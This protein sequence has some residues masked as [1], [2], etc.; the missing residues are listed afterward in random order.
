MIGSMTSQN[1]S[2]DW[3]SRGSL[4]RSSTWTPLHQLV[5]D[6]SAQNNVDVAAPT[7]VFQ[8]S[9]TFA[10]GSVEARV[11]E[12]LPA[13]LVIT[14]YAHRSSS[15]I[16][17]RE[18]TVSFVGCLK[19]VKFT[20]DENAKPVA[21]STNSLM[22]LYDIP[23]GETRL[24]SES[25]SS[26][27]SSPESIQPLVGASDLTFS[28]GTIKVF[29]F[30]LLPRDAG[31]V[32][33]TLAS[34]DIHEEFFDFTVVTPLHKQVSPNDWWLTCGTI[35]SKRKLTTD[36][37]WSI[38][39][40]PKPPKVDIHILNLLKSYYTD[41][42]VELQFTITNNEVE[43]A[44]IRFNVQ[45]QGS[46][47]KAPVVRWKSSSTDKGISIM[48]DDVRDE[49]VNSLNSQ[50]AGHLIGRMA[51]GEA[52]TE[53]ITFQAL[54]EMVD[55]ILEVT[56]NYHLLSDPDTPISKTIT[57]DLVFIGP[58][59]ANYVTTPRVHSSPW[60][61]YF[62]MGEDDDDQSQ[63]PEKSRLEGLQ[64]KWLLSARVASFAIE[65]LRI[66]DVALEIVD[67][68]HGAVCRV[69]QT[70]NLPKPP[71]ILSPNE[72]LSREFLFEVHK[73]SLEDR[74][75]S[76][77]TF[78][79]CVLW[80][81]ESPSSSSSTAT[82]LL[83]SPITIPFGEPRVVASVSQ[84]IGS[85]QLPL[86]HISYT[87]ENPSMHLLTFSVS[88]EANED[89]AFSGPKAITVQLVPLSQ[90]NIRYNLLPAQKGVWI[91]PSLKVVDMG[92]GKT[93]M[94]GAGEGCRG[95]SKGIAI[96]VSSDE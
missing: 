28:P 48:Q 68:R 92:F 69:S 65:A 60:P 84:S 70:P 75:A 82:S 83:V 41:E 20:H 6:H 21:S 93:L 94:V 81:R 45:L 23:I 85:E 3:I 14:S 71:A 47:N 4:I 25:S 30:N 61:S 42:K 55:Y 63:S 74:R 27:P 56:A 35:V 17:L 36:H 66:E 91:W 80:R 37:S 18:V 34:I 59:E 38:N 53:L 11:G 15:P 64:Q 54:P 12:P 88:M 79:L 62:H 33:A 5:S 9:I 73:R 89:F 86:V 67:V 10:F 76:S 13:Q 95:D 43:D 50:P 49:V 31:E 78:R 40:L 44:E 19:I 1:A 16:I 22:H 52:R 87:L 8:V 72:I 58:F 57:K 24:S 29:T 2:T 32:K 39:V 90:H 77:V 51:P 46:L 96:W 7:D 26:R